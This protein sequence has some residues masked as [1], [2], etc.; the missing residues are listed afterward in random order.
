MLPAAAVWLP[1]ALLAFVARLLPT[2][3][4]GGLG[5]YDDYDDYDD[6]VYFGGS[7]ALIAGRLPYQDFVLLHPP[8]ILL[9]LSPLAALA[10]V[11]SDHRAFELARVAFMALGS[12]NAVLTAAVAGRS[13]LRGP[14][15]AVVAG[16]LY[17]LWPPAIEADS[18]TMLEPLNTLGLLVA[19]LLLYRRPT[20]AHQEFLA[21]VALGAATAVKVWG[22]VPLVVVLVWELVLH[23]PRAAA[24]VALGAASALTVVC[25]PFFLAAPGA[26]YR[27]VVVDQLERGEVNRGVL[28]R[29][30][31]IL[32]VSR[33]QSGARPPG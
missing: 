31:G 4:G 9:V 19:L 26:M 29:L 7:Q 30:S 33:F 28:D 21:G 20:S 23:L 25:L 11:V 6:G 24:Q 18:T 15:A 16:T 8:G 3:H 10:R 27:M 2:L 1:I 13:R 12:L 5:G 22:V 32:G 17:A 14:V